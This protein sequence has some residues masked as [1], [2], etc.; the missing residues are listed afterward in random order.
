MNRLKIIESAVFK[1]C[2]FSLFLK[3]PI[4]QVIKMLPKTKPKHTPETNCLVVFHGHLVALNVV[5]ESYV[6][7]W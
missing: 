7:L 4:F 3:D 2:R 5:F 6:D 1:Y